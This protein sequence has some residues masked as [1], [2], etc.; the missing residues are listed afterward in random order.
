M[1][2]S[3]V[4]CVPPP[5]AS[6]GAQTSDAGCDAMVMQSMRRRLASG[7]I[8][9]LDGPTGTELQRRGAPMSGGAWC[10]LATGTH[11]ELLLEIHE[12]Y[13]RAGADIVT[14]NTYSNARHMLDEAGAPE[15]AG[16]LTRNAVEIAMRARDRAAGGRDVAVA[17][18]L[19]HQ[20]PMI[21]GTGRGDPERRPPS[22]QVLDNFRELVAAGVDA[23]ADMIILEAVSRPEHI[24]LALQA[25][26]ESGLPYWC[27]LSAVRENGVILSFADERFP[28]AESIA[29]GL[30]GNAEVVGVMHS[31]VDVTTPALELLRQSWPGPMM[32]YPESGHFT[33]PRWQFEDVITPDDLATE[34]AVWRDIGVQ[35]LGGCCG[36]GLE[37][38][39][40]LAGLRT[41]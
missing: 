33:M 8:I 3:R 2:W 26:E 18:S 20:M 30:A 27:G 13:V 5:D 11:P 41:S 6:P 38:L 22:R 19:S 12:D 17:L 29:A 40:A 23:G 24:A 9:L 16:D 10:A 36:L 14:A 15:K 37:H 21:A 28:F 31:G 1:V 35:V 25:V 4:G 39:R 7:E 34:A 32:A